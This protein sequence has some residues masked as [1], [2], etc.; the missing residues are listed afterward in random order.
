MIALLLGTAFAAQLTIT[1]LTTGDIRLL[2]LKSKCGPENLIPLA[3][4]TLKPLEHLTLDKLQP[5]V[6]T[7]DICGGGYCARSAIGMNKEVV[8]YD[9]Q[10]RPNINYGISPVAVPDVWPG[11][12]DCEEVSGAE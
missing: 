12:L 4:K 2:V 3:P 11:N 10:V 5:V 6:Y 1:N 7:Y 9:L 8:G